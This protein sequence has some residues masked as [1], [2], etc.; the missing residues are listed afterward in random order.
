[1]ELYYNI[2]NSIELEVVC[3]RRVLDENTDIETF[4]V[5]CMC[6]YVCLENPFE[7]FAELN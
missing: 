6:V 4:I 3:E 7:I 1:M 2:L 5:L